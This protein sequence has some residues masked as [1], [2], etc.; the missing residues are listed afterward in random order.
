[1]S[2][3]NKLSEPVAR[4]IAVDSGSIADAGLPLAGW[5]SANKGNFSLDATAFS[6][7]GNRMSRVF[8]AFH[9]V[10][11]SSTS[12]RRVPSDG[13]LTVRPA[14]IDLQLLNRQRL[15]V[16]SAALCVYADSALSFLRTV[17]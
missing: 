12:S 4:C 2:K 5:H 1:M 8:P 15:R 10:C 16:F 14:P 6:S 13:D 9:P 17:V 3:D 11:K 7:L